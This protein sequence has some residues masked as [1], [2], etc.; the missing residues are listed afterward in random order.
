MRSVRGHGFDFVTTS[1]KKRPDP[2]H[3]NNPL[4]ESDSLKNGPGVR[5]HV[6]MGSLRSAP[7]GTH[8]LVEL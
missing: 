3:G 5:S 8:C 1:S 7:V 2:L 6:Y 4:I